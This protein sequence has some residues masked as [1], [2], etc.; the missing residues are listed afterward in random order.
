MEKRTGGGATSV[1]I[2]LALATLLLSL[3]TWPGSV[4]SAQVSPS[5]S[6][7]ASP[8][9]P[10]PTPSDQPTPTPSAEP[11][12][13]PSDAAPSASTTSTPTVGPILA[14]PFTPLP[15]EPTGRL[16]TRRSERAPHDWLTRAEGRGRKHRRSWKGWAPD[17]RWGTYGTAVL[18]RAADRARKKGWDPRRIANEIYAPFL[19]V[20]PATWS[21]SWGAPRFAGGYHPHHGQDILCRYGAPVLAVQ[22]GIVRFGADPLGGRE[23]FLE[24]KDG[25]YWYYAH[26]KSYATGLSSGDR[27]NTGRIIGR[28]GASGD[29]T[30]PHVHFAL[31]T[32]EHVA[33]DPMRALIF[34]LRGA[35][36]SLPGMRHQPERRPVPALL[37]PA[38]REPVNLAGTPYAEGSVGSAGAESLSPR[39]RA[40]GVAA[41][42][43]LS[44]PIAVGL[45]R[46]R[47]QRAPEPGAA[48]P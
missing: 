48:V 37:L 15:R 18:D 24:R 16:T 12:P 21:D 44:C 10:T 6:S 3:A 11:T 20:G 2:G 43:M 4:A 13:T 30:V 45:A 38:P 46:R 8:S 29:A 39:Q 25:S 22:G 31:F 19:L 34:W 42:M 32:A 47:K 41:V 40:M 26:L 1:R 5:P 33:V 35:Q 9:E 36:K 28:C 23:A 7:S 17:P 14:P 27:V